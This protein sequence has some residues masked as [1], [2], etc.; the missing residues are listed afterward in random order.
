MPLTERGN[1][2]CRGTAC[3]ARALATRRGE[4]PTACCIFY[5]NGN[6]IR[7][8]KTVH[9]VHPTGLSIYGKVR[10]TLFLRGP[11]ALRR[12]FC[13]GGRVAGSAQPRAAARGHRRGLIARFTRPQR[14]RWAAQLSD[15]PASPRQDEPAALPDCSGS[16]KSRCSVRACLRSLGRREKVG[17]RG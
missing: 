5:V 11:L 2:S 17:N 1:P 12:D 10:S 9:G 16:R 8:H 14:S 6:A 3:R 7:D 15:E 13:S 4:S